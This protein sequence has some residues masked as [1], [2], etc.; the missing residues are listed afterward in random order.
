MAELHK[1]QVAWSAARPAGVK[2]EK[3]KDYYSDIL[4]NLGDMTNRL[5]EGVA[6]YQDNKLKEALEVAELE[7]RSMLDNAQSATADYDKVMVMAQNKMSEQLSQFDK[8][9]VNR[10]MQN[11][12]QYFEKVNI[13]LSQKA[14]QKK[15]E[16]L[17]NATE[18]S[19]PLWTSKAIL[20][21]DPKERQAVI[22]KIQN[23]VG[24]YSIK[25]AD[26]LIFKANSM[27]DNANVANLLLKNDFEGVRN[28]LKNAEITHTI[29]AS[30]RATWISRLEAREKEY[31]KLQEETK[32]ALKDPRQLAIVD[33]Y[34]ALKQNG[35]FSEADKLRNDVYKGVPISA[36]WEE[37]ITEDGRSMTVPKFIDISD[38][39]PTERAELTKKIDQYADLNPDQTYENDVYQQRVTYVLGEYEKFKKAGSSQQTE[40]IANLMDLMAN[41][42]QYNTI[43][44][45]T[46]KEI[47]K[48][49]SMNI[50]A[51][52]EAAQPSILTPVSDVFY[53][54]TWFTDYRDQSPQSIIRSAVLGLPVSRGALS[55]IHA[56][57]GQTEMT[58]EQAGGMETVLGRA[59]ATDVQ[60]YK[61]LFEKDMERD[62]IAEF[63]RYNISLINALRD[64]NVLAN[65]GIAA[66]S[67]ER[68]EESWIVWASDLRRKGI[69]NSVATKD[70][71]DLIDSYYEYALNRGLNQNEKEAVAKLK[72]Y[73]ATAQP[74]AKGEIGRWWKREQPEQII[75][76]STTQPNSVAR[77]IGVGNE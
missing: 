69:Y 47:A 12:P 10:F 64:T 8:A 34:N 24:P 63:G 71:R 45:K 29:D 49:V 15:G 4:D 48:A 27:M 53:E 13:A 6:A 16:Q 14:L 51:R 70:N 77:Y 75:N 46:R 28:L 11:N 60:N 43:E 20:S 55:V 19:L 39:T 25:A 50:S 44:S 17:I 9:T 21:G 38:L 2:L 52:A 62:S 54:G 66:L 68:L 7:A 58:V 67:R 42:T 41:K 56:A 22:E 57:G 59:L 33:A 36:G 1:N 40:A 61:E 72:E 35:M 32:K 23:Q 74:D 26:E 30:E 18:Q 65:T 3:K 31:Y 76:V 37:V 5:A 73:A